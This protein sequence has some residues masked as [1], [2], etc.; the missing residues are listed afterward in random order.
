LPRNFC[1]NFAGEQ[2]VL[3][4]WA[5]HLLPRIDA[6][7]LSVS[8]EVFEIESLNLLTKACEQLTP[9]SVQRR[10]PMWARFQKAERQT[11]P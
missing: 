4:F 3:T 10:L 2:A 1:K 8:R 5:V 6:V 7:E 11:N 9:L